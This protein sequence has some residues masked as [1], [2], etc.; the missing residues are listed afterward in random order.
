MLREA[1]S[2]EPRFRLEPA[3]PAEME[4][5]SRVH[6]ANYAN[7]FVR[8]TLETSVMRRIGFPWSPEL[9]KRTLASVGAT[10]LA[11]DA[12][13]A[14]GFGGTLAGGTHHAFRNEGSGFCV[15]N[16]IAIAIERA[17]F[18]Y[19]LTKLAIVDLDVHQGD[20]SASIFQNDS[21]VFTLSLHG[22]R[23]F[24]FRKQT[25]TLDV[26]LGDGT[27]D[28][29]YLEALVPALER[30]WEFEPQAVFFQAGVDGL[31]SDR[32]GR[33]GLTVE[34][35]RQR[36]LLVATQATQ[37]NV[38]LVVT[39]GGGYSDPIDLTVRAH[40]QTFQTLADVFGRSMCSAAH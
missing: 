26:S 34:G 27:G 33:L 18:K 37:L 15:F 9:A 7:D 5:V 19:G 20:G 30:V 40:A 25:S 36:D 10:L 35:L 38:P 2:T 31:R 32:L 14:Q 16:D 13:L 29:E 39:I 11:S 4:D 12:A 3:I 23:N 22:H 8:G 6:T 28:D 1:L 24:P 17:R 21:G